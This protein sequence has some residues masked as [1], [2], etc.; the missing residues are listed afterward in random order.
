METIKNDDLRW[1]YHGGTH[2]VILQ[3][4]VTII[5]ED[6]RTAKIEWHDIP[7]VREYP[8]YNSP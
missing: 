7:L 6:E 8:R 4:K 2:Y 5:N 1:A 3:R